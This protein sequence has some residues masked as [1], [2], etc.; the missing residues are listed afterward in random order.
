ML[1]ICAADKHVVL[2]ASKT[3]SKDE[4]KDYKGKK[5]GAKTRSS[6]IQTRSKSMETK[7]GS[8]KDQ[9]EAGGPTSLGVTSEEGA[10]PQLGSG[11][12]TSNLNKL[13]FLASFIIH[14]ESTSGRDASADS[15]DEAGTG[16]NVLT[17]KT[18]SEA[19]LGGD[20]FT[21]SD[22]IFKK[23]KLE[24][25]SKLVQNVKA[26]FMDLD[27][28][29]DEPIIMVDESEDDEEDKDE[30]VHATSNLKTKGTSAHK[31]PS[32]RSIQV[33]EL[34]NQVLIL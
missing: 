26:D 4:K 27:S 16:P 23:I 22:E 25:L 8:S 21:S 2:K 1:A 31:P 9:Q 29:E 10:H 20:K 11:V 17:D 34:T 3:S 18:Q 28:P 15:T 24:D 7:D 33:Q 19:S 14:S 6:K 12:S 32:L 5:P 30:E 13:I